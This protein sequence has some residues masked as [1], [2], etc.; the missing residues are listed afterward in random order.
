MLVAF[1][2][3]DGPLA[4]GWRCGPVGCELVRLV[5]VHGEVLCSWD[6]AGTHVRT[7][8]RKERPNSLLGLQMLVWACIVGWKQAQIRPK[9]DPK[10]LGPRAK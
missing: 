9:V 8:G 4:H 6:S 3:G 1:P 2:L 7:Q 5:Y 10:K